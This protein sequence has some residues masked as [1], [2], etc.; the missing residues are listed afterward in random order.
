MKAISGWILV[1]L[2]FGLIIFGIGASDAAHNKE[3]KQQKEQ[4]EQF[5]KDCF[6]KGGRVDTAGSVWTKLFLVCNPK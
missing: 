3:V 5:A 2:F 6:N 1:I 4:V